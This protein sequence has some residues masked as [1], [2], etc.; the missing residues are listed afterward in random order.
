MSP[1]TPT[2]LNLPDQSTATNPKS[3]SLNNEE[4]LLN[5]LFTDDHK[6]I[7]IQYHAYPPN[8]QV[9]N[10]L[11]TAGATVMEVGYLMPMLYRPESLKYG[12]TAANNS[13]QATGLECGI[14]SPPFTENFIEIPIVDREAYDYDWRANKTQ[15][16]VTTVG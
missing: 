3:P 7:A 14:Q 4:G 13:W 12:A 11:S 16:E 10:F 5:R 9:L 6:R 2:I 8:Y 1:A 15:Q